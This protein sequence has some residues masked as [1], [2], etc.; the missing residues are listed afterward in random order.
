MQED[1]KLKG[2]QQVDENYIAPIMAHSPHLA[3][4]VWRGISDLDV[5]RNGFL[6]VDELHGCFTE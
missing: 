4:K 3:A 6:S 1:Y 2:L 5:D